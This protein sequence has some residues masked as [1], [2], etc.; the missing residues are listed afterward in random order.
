[1]FNIISFASNDNIVPEEEPENL[2]KEEPVK[3]NLFKEEPEKENLFKEE[4]VKENLFK[5]E[6]VK[7]NLFKEEPVKENLFVNTKREKIDDDDEDED[8]DNR[9]YV[10][11]I[12]NIPFYYHHDLISLRQQMWS[13]ANT[14][15]KPKTLI[16]FE[17][18]CIISNNINEIKIES[19][20]DFFII[21]YSN[22]LYT[23]K[24][25]YILPLN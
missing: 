21:N 8:D 16:E 15:M 22:N 14:Y 12:N 20:Y 10:L 13:M 2:F 11:S 4:P 6:P 24:I 25:D 19:Q 18:R 3:E 7:E 1:M 17:N 9:L 23:L 5:E